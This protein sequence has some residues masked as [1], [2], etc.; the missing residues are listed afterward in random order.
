MY[1]PEAEWPLTLSGPFSST[2]EKHPVNVIYVMTMREVEWQQTREGA[3]QSQRPLGLRPVHTIPKS[4]LL[5]Y[6]H[7][8]KSKILE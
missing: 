3:W 5:K 7:L 8:K 6:G 4:Y 1:W 2:L